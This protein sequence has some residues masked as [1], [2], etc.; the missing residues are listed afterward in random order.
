MPLGPFCATNSTFWPSLR[1]RKPEPWISLKWAKR[2]AP[3]SAGV[4]KP[5]PL[6]SLNHF[7]VPVDTL[8][9]LIVPVGVGGGSEGTNL[10]RLHAL[11]A[12][13][14]DE[15]DLLSFLEGLEAA[16]LDLLEVREEVF[17]ATRRSDEAEALGFVEPFDGS[18]CCSSHNY[19]SL[20]SF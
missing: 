3:P 5:K 7:T 6:A 2:S 1:V 17:A 11:R 20:L 19:V 18:S 9:M 13:L 8:D 14:R 10:G 4:M 12:A 15:L 16:S